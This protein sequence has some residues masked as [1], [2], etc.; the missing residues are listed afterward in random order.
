M[1]RI[2]GRIREMKMRK[3]IFGGLLSL[4]LAGAA[5]G[6]V[7]FQGAQSPGQ[8]GVVASGAAGGVPY[9]SPTG[10]AA[11]ASTTSCRLVAT[12]GVPPA[13]NATSS[14]SAQTP[15]ITE[16]YLAEAYVPAPCSATGVAN[17]NSATI[18]G[19]VKVGL[20]NAAGVLIAT[21]ATTAQSGTSAFQ[22]V[23]FTAVIT[24]NPGTYY[25]A[26][27]Y[28][29]T[30][31]RPQ[32]WTTGAF[33]AGKLTGQTYATGFPANAT[34]PTTFTTALGGAATLY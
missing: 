15:V 17:L 33:G 11:I 12:G 2:T 23:P 26:T 8:L 31:T 10:A 34:M 27:F 4:L 21:S 1:A 6:Q 22:L 28:D 3:F 16:V 32:A 14:Y 24:V 29:N 7:Y 25:I 19:N 30:T 9:V 18:S 5:I 20:Y 13:L